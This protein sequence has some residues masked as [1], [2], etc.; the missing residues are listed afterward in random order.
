MVPYKLGQKLHDEVVSHRKI[1]GG[2]PV[3]LVSFGAIFGYG[4]NEISTDGGLPKIIRYWAAKYLR[5]MPQPFCSHRDFLKKC[6]ENIWTA[7]DYAT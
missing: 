3:K 4:H 2:K 5:S 6:S 1:K 7:D